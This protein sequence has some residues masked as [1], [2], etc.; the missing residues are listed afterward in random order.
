MRKSSLRLVSPKRENG[1]SRRRGCPNAV[2]RPREHLTEREVE[3]LIER[4]QE[5]P[6]RPAGRRPAPAGLPA[7]AYVRPKS[8]GCIGAD[9]EF[10][11]RHRASAP[12]Q[13]RRGERASTQS[14]TNCGCYGLL[15]R[16]CKVALRVL[17][18]ARRTFYRRRSSKAC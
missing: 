14:T 17:H 6:A 10:A 15:K 2:L 18:R 8:A 9:V 5:Q 13:G 11:E 7:R 4:R 1:Q 16:E 12:R 3:K